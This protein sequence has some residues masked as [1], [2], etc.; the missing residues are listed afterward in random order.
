M[1]PVNPAGIAG[2]VSLSTGTLA[3]PPANDSAKIHDAA[4]QFEAL[5][6]GQILHSVHDGDSGW[7]G[8]G[9]DSSSG[10]AGDYAE[11]QLAASIAQHGG[12][13]LAKLITDGLERSGR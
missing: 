13:G 10:C 1:S 8:S 4:Q 12:L 9:G 7:M 11:Q 5:L 2:A 3:A 6:L